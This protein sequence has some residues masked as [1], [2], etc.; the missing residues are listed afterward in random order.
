MTTMMKPQDLFTLGLR[1]LRNKQFK[2]AQRAF[3]EVTTQEPNMCDAWLGRLAAGDQSLEVLAGAY[4]SRS[5]LGQLLRANQLAV[6]NLEIATT[7]TLGVF[8]L[9]MPV[10]SELNVAI[11]YAVALAEST[12]PRLADAAEVVERH[13][14]RT[15][16]SPED[17]DVLDYVHLGL[18]GLAK[19]WPDVL[20]FEQTQRW[21]SDNENLLAVLSEG[22]RVWKAWA[23]IG[24]GSASEA[25]KYCEV[26]INRENVPPGVH[27]QL[28]L[29]RA[30]AMRAIGRRD[31]AMKALLELKAWSPTPEVL[32]AIENP[33]KKVELVTAQS[34]ATRSN[35]WDPAS[36]ESAGAL[37][38]AQRERE[39]SV[40]IK[41]AMSELDDQIGMDG[42]K[43]QLKMLHAS[44]A[45]SKKRGVD[46]QH[47]KAMS[48]VFA[49]PPGTGKTTMARLLA[50]ILFGLGL[51]AKPTVVEGSKAEMVAGYLGQ[52]AEKT[53]A[54][55]DKSLGG[56]LFIDEAYSLIGEGYSDGDAFGEEAVNTLL[57]RMENERA[58]AD[59][60]MKLVVVIAGYRAD[61]DRLL[62]SNDGL[63]SRFN[64]GIDFESYTADQLVQIAALM[65]PQFEGS[66]YG[67]D[68]LDVLREHLQRL[69]N[70][71][72]D[73][74]DAAGRPR[75]LPALDKAG[76]ARFVRLITEKAT[77]YRD[78]RLAMGDEAE[79]VGE[80]LVTL[81]ASDVEEAVAEMSQSQKVPYVASN[82]PA[83][84]Q[85]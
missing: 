61:I 51:I 46:T 37:D 9:R 20:T 45:M 27:L 78:L 85:S 63:R 1:S 76:N 68:G 56:L 74:K 53:N 19:R 34:L 5:Q 39:R 11:A 10:A 65:A 81:R 52:T 84:Q 30:Y 66:T 70:V 18:L 80:A 71:V 33:D 43:K 31:E 59:P 32:E 58:T 55:I 79:Q 67:A 57:A 77:L 35:I 41:E 47:Q 62:D 60:M 3:V 14:K 64:T 21:H 25:V 54:F 42:V 4:K 49:G 83:L 16:A 6:A 13:G 7:M 36:G 72:V 22:V 73:D 24:T 26:A 50:K 40:V 15:T 38:E 28:R 17:Q 75:Q 29:A 69:E 48:F 44:V 8:D 12:P 2:D 82:N 23:L